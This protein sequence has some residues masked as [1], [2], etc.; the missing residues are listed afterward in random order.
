LDVDTQFR[1]TSFPL[2]CFCD[3][4]I[5]L[6]G[7]FLFP[8]KITDALGCL[9]FFFSLIDVWHFFACIDREEAVR[10]HGERERDVYDMRQRSL[11]GIE[12][13]TWLAQ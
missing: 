3:K 13:A 9:N 1:A 7:I 10:K 4:K 11:A 8:G 6:H 2:W 12:P 5:S